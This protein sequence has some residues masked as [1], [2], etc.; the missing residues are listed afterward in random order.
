MSLQHIIASPWQPPI[1]EPPNP[2]SADSPNGIQHASASRPL[3]PPSLAA[4]APTT[5]IQ[6]PAPA[7][8]GKLRSWR[9]KYKKLKVR[10]DAA[11]GESNRLFKDEKNHLG[12]CRR[13]QEDIE[14]V[15]SPR[16]AGDEC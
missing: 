5:T 15:L 14:C 10:F 4:P 16:L 2:P 7:P 3:P 9:K 12:R 13:I 6:P 8:P 1:S 11:M